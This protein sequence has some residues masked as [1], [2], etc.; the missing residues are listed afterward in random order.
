MPVN[1]PSDYFP[2][3]IALY[4]SIMWHISTNQIA[5][6]TS[7]KIKWYVY[8]HFIYFNLEFNGYPDF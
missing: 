3:E 7:K 5:L 8:A 6:S 2:N 4:C 1:S